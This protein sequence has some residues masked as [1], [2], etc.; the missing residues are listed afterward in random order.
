MN[1]KANSNTGKDSITYQ[2]SDT[3]F[4]GFDDGYRAIDSSIINNSEIHLGERTK[5]FT[6]RYFTEE[7]LSE[8]TQ[9]YVANR[10]YSVTNQNL[11]MGGSGSLEA[12]VNYKIAD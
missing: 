11:P 12:A 7:E 6:T 9:K 4:L 8:F 5:S 1:L 3:D 10:D 2:G